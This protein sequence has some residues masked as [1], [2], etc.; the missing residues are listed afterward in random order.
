MSVDSMS[1][2]SGESNQTSRSLPVIASKNNFLMNGKKKSVKK[3]SLMMEEV[4]SDYQEEFE[5]DDNED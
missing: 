3:I 5:S 1:V 4:P 2:Y